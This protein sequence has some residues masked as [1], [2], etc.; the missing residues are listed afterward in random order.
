MTADSSSSNADRRGRLLLAVGAAVGIL[1]AVASAIKPAGDGLPANAVA[2]VNDRVVAAEELARAID[3][4]A[5]DK[6]NEMT[7]EDRAFVLDRLIDEE[8]LVQRG[9][10]LGLVDSDQSVRKAIVKAMMDSILMDA[11]SEKPTEEELRAFYRDNQDYFARPPTL[12][13]RQIL[14]RN[15]AERAD[16][17]QRA[18]QAAGAMASGVSFADVVAQFGDA[19]IQ[20]IPDTLLPLRALREYVGPTAL[21]TLMSMQAGER[22]PPIPSPFGYQIVELV[23]REGT[24]VP[25]FDS[26]AEHVE[27]V[28]I[29]RAGEKALRDYLARL[30]EE[31][32]LRY[33]ADAPRQ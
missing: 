12:R 2:A 33:A 19:P 1:V 8:L 28:Y 22:T 4:L 21:E 30:R 9:V 10:E 17:L 15:G 31:A 26:V 27:P 11:E 20:P 5:Q 16:G 29:R 25:T 24:D 3:L 14:F 32:R 13:V 6:R 18:E 7:E 23:E